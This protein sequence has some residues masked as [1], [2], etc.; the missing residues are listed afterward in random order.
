MSERISEQMNE[1][2]KFVSTKV[3]K[4]ENMR[5]IFNFLKKNDSDSFIWHVTFESWR[6][7]NV[8]TDSEVALQP[9]NCVLSLS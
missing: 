4:A 9:I 8:I 5:N 3:N 1:F 6:V 7:I 2:I